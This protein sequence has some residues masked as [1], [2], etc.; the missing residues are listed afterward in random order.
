MQA[1]STDFVWAIVRTRQQRM[2]QRRMADKD[3]N[4]LKLDMKWCKHAQDRLA[5]VQ[6]V[7]IVCIL[8]G[9]GP[10]QRMFNNHPT[11][12]DNVVYI[13]NSAVRVW[14]SAGARESARVEE[15]G[16]RD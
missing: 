5:W 11:S 13:A 12:H 15:Q 1:I 6:A 10:T 4:A 9:P 7:M 8:P 16:S 3:L 14:V 2:L